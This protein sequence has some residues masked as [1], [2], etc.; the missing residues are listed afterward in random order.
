[1][2]VARS[3]LNTYIT[4]KFFFLLK[5]FYLTCLNV[6]VGLYSETKITDQEWSDIQTRF[7]EEMFMFLITK[8]RMCPVVSHFSKER[9]LKK[10]QTN[11]RKRLPF[12]P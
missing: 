4:Y 12:S 8:G 10:G 5:H 3:P 1:M 11:V 2:L 6:Y 9:N 7:L